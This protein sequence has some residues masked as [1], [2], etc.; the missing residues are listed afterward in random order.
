MLYRRRPAPLYLLFRGLLGS[1]PALCCDGGGGLQL[2]AH[3][4]PPPASPHINTTYFSHMQQ[5]GG[6]LL[7]SPF[8]PGGGGG[9]AMPLSSAPHLCVCH[10][11]L[12]AILP[13]HL[14]LLW[15]ANIC[16][17]HSFSYAASS[18]RHLLPLPCL[19]P[20]TYVTFMWRFTS[21]TCHMT[22]V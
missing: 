13:S 3:P 14:F 12:I 22:L 21:A 11:C 18:A 9:R 6:S 17:T 10:P 19:S 5:R 7:T 2:T 4:L 8:M 20:Y 15:C 1:R 16:H